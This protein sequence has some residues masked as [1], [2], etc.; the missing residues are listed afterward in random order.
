MLVHEE[1]AQSAE[2]E[3]E[4]A[5]YETGAAGGADSAKYQSES[6][7]ETA[8]GSKATPRIIYHQSADGSKS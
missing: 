4:T 3:S 8:A 5:E 7:S 6:E 2:N 1:A